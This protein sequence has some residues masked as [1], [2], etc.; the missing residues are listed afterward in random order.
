MRRSVLVA[1]F[2]AL[3]AGLLGGCDAT[4]GGLRVQQPS[5]P[6]PYNSPY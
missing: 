5:S 6:F 3:V 1:L 4:S 2:I